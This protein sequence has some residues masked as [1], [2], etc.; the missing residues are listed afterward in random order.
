MQLLS[1]RNI[2]NEIDIDWFTP[3][4]L[5]HEDLV[6]QGVAEDHTHKLPVP[7]ALYVLAAL[8]AAVGVVILEG[9][10]NPDGLPT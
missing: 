10:G 4:P 5:P 2:Y 3:Q 8:A 9:E 6:S 7:G 1:N